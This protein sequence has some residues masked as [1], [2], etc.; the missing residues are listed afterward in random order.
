M[1]TRNPRSITSYADRDI[2]T[3]CINLHFIRGA[4][5]PEEAIGKPVE[6]LPLEKADDSPY[7]GAVAIPFEDATLLM[8]QLWGAGVRPTDDIG[9][10]GQLSAMKDH[11]ASLEKHLADLRKYLD[12]NMG[13]VP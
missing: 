6:F 9:S 13:I 5:T 1:A 10:T 12:H 8:N 2:R 4:G 3:R 11:I 7:S